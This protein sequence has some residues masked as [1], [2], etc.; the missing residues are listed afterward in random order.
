MRLTLCAVFL[1]FL[2]GCVR[3]SIRSSTPAPVADTQNSY[4]DLQPGWRL[5]VIVPLTKSGSFKVAPTQESTVGNAI[6]FRVGDDFIGYE[7]AYYA[8]QGRG[9]TGVRIAFVAAEDTKNGVTHAQ[10]VPSVQLFQLPHEVKYVRLIYVTRKSQSDHEMAVLAAKNQVVLDSLTAQ[11]QENPALCRDTHQGSCSW[12]PTGIA[13][14]PEV[15]KN[16]GGVEAWM[17]VR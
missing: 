7:T 10:P 16:D 14:R 8:V 17:P 13:V 6:T 12:I 11:V 9:R 5:R 3:K 4:V 1:V 2:V 15:R